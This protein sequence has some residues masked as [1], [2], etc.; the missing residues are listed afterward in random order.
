MVTSSVI[1]T[2]WPSRSASHRD[3]RPGS[4]RPRRPHPRAP[5]GGRGA[6]STSNASWRRAGE[7]ASA[8]RCRS[9][10]LRCRG[11]AGRAPRSRSPGRACRMAVRVPVAEPS[12]RVLRL[13]TTSANPALHRLDR[14]IQRQ[15]LGEVLLGRL[16]QLAVHDAVGREVFDELAGHP[17]QSASVC[18]TAT[19]SSNVL[20]YRTSV[21]E[22]D[23]STNQAARSRVRRPAVRCPVS[24]RSR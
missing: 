19:V 20:R 21:P 6:A 2:P 14:L 23:A 17:A 11:A 5:A 15:P 13:P 10:R 22:P 9:P 18:I 4:S 16:A 3:R 8:R 1:R 12:C 7:P 24:R